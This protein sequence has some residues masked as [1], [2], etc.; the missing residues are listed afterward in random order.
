L[1][2]FSLLSAQI[3][4]IP[5]QNFEQDLINQ[6]ID[7]DGVVNG[8]VLTSDI[9]NLNNLTLFNFLNDIT[10]LQDFSQ[11]KNLEIHTLYLPYE[12]DQI[13]DLTSNVMLEKLT[14]Y[15]GD[16]A[17]T[18]MINTIDLSSNPNIYEIHTP[19]IWDLKQIDLK[20]G[21]TDVSNLDIDI[22]VGFPLQPGG[23]NEVF[24][25][26]LFCIKVTDEAAAT[27][28]TGVYSTWNITADLNPYYFSETCTLSTDRF[29]NA[30]INIYP[31]PT[32]HFLNIETMNIHLQSIKVFN[33]QGQL[34]KEIKDDDI[35]TI[36]VSDLSYG[37][38]VI[39][40]ESD[41][42]IIKKKF[43]KQ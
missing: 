10:G 15:G 4:L 33:I 31:N 8:Q 38:Y 20:S 13:L 41:F 36:D 25:K 29:K 27:A 35:K 39:Q 6:N 5:D 3:T 9:E 22:S 43:I 34:V 26:N 18:H 23:P 28:G 21:T 16:D 2:F 24:N 17:V 42:G 32:S 11:L 7:S 1:I 14:M 19:G 37:L 40:I 12:S 30:D